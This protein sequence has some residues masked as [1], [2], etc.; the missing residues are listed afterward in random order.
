MAT[1]YVSKGGSDANDGSSWALSKLTIQGAA[2][3]AASGDT[4]EI[5]SG[6]YNEAVSLTAAEGYSFVADGHVVM[7][8]NAALA[9]AFN[10]NVGV[11]S[12]T[13]RYTGIIFKNYTGAAVTQWIGGTYIS[14]INVDKCV[15]DSCGSGFA[16]GTASSG[17]SSVSVTSC[18]I[19]CTSTGVSSASSSGYGYATVRNCTIYASTGSGIYAGGTNTSSGVS[20]QDSIFYTCNRSIELGSSATAIAAIYN[21]IHYGMVTAT[22]RRGGVDYNFAAW[23]A[24][25][26]DAN[27]QN[28]DPQFTDPA[29]GVY[30]FTTASPASTAGRYGVFAGWTPPTWVR[31]N[32]NDPESKW[33]VQ[34]STTLASDAGSYWV[35]SVESGV[36]ENGSGHFVLN[37]SPSCTLTSPVFDGNKAVNVFRFGVLLNETNPTN[38]IDTEISD[39]QPNRRNIEYRSSASPFYQD[40]GVIAW[41]TVEMNT[42]LTSPVSLGRYRQFRFTFRDNGVAA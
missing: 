7:R 34:T 38:V 9:N 39:A 22:G 17:T 8:N 33:Q 29:N 35:P 16:S 42:D 12:I 15:V 2:N 14:T 18:L 40:D 41:S 10:C 4:I 32:N 23:Q 27:S 28:V 6:E 36:T 19:R 1:K 26:A 20:A 5:G 31:S 37:T 13:H 3:A 24:L 11:T 21:N 25:G 30:S